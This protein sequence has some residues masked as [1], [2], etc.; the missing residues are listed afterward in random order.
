MLHYI[1]DT[2]L[3]YIT[4]TPGIRRQSGGL[5]A[6][7]SG[8]GGC[9]PPCRPGPQMPINYTTPPRGIIDLIYRIDPPQGYGNVREPTSHL[10]SPAGG[11]SPQTGWHRESIPGPPASRT[12]VLPTALTRPPSS[13]MNSCRISRTTMHLVTVC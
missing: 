3:H 10:V 9:S 12:D 4:L 5:R 6:L 13:V 7:L 11:T 2:M 8:G 1:K